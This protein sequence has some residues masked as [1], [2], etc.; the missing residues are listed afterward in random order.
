MTYLPHL[1]YLA[2][3]LL[4][5]AFLGQRRRLLKTQ[6]RVARLARPA[7]RSPELTDDQLFDRLWR[8]V[9]R[10]KV[11]VQ[12]RG[13][14][15]WNQNWR[16]PSYG[17]DTIGRYDLDTGIISL[18]PKIGRCPWT[19]AH[20]LGHRSLHR[21]GKQK[22]TEPEADARGRELLLSVLTPE[23]A[24]GVMSRIDLNLPA[25]PSGGKAP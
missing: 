21:G 17:K 2:A 9:E 6:R 20:E 15:M 24:E 22:H 10:E 7:S 25:L 3:T 13:W 19:L 23:E 11:P 1:L 12:C 18:H 8:I 4:V 16:D 14:G 5:V